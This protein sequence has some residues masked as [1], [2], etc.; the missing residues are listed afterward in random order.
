MDIAERT[1]TAHNQDEELPPYLSL[2]QC[3]NLEE[4]IKGKSKDATWSSP[5]RREYSLDSLKLDAEGFKRMRDAQGG[6]HLIPGTGPWV[7]SSNVDGVGDALFF[8]PIRAYLIQIPLTSST[9]A[10][11]DLSGLDTL[12]KAVKDKW[13]MS[14]WLETGFA[15]VS[16]RFPM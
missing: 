10:S 3:I 13:S 1:I 15:I 6:E 7:G 16:P 8:G 11:S 4:V 2:L 12:R 14:E 9:S 5:E